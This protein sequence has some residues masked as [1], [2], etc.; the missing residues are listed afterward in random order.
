MNLPLPA[1]AAPEL[2]RDLRAFVGVCEDLLQ[3]SVREH[4]ALSA[5][6]DFQPD[7]FGNARKDLLMRLNEVLIAVK[8]WRKVWQKEDPAQRTRHPEVKALLEVLQQMIVKILQL[9]RENQQSLLRRGLLPARNVP[10]FAPQP[11]SFVSK[12][13]SRHTS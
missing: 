9:D 5:T 4:H 1:T 6:E 13:Y 11:P 7:D 12:L 10:S 8:N 3:L 2:L